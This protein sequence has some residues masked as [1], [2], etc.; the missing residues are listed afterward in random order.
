[1]VL[2]AAVAAVCFP[3]VWGADQAPKP[4]DVNTDEIIQKFAAKEA[5]FQD[6]RNNYTYRQTVKM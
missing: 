1:M 2:S 3:I 5:E 6:A 4:A